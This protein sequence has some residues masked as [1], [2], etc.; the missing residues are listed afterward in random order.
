MIQLA[1]HTNFPLSPGQMKHAKHALV[2][3]AIQAG[4]ILQETYTQPEESEQTRQIPQPLRQVGSTA[5]SYK[6]S[7]ES[8]QEEMAALV[9][10]LTSTSS[11]ALLHVD[12]ALPLDPRK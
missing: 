1:F 11:S 12:P 8:N 3:D 10:F 4:E 5:Q 6:F 7:S 9:S 2:L